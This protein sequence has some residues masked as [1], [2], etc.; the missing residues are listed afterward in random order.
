[1]SA[2]KPTAEQISMNPF[3]DHG[4]GCEFTDS[5]AF[6]V[7]DKTVKARMH[8]AKYGPPEETSKRTAQAWSA[9]FGF[10]IEPHQVLMALAVYHAIRYSRDP[11]DGKTL[12]DL[13]G[14]VRMAE[15]LRGPPGR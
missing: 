15:I 1:M 6:M 2:R 13:A 11:T 10:Q 12:H 3:T 7:A 5:V 9:I 8:D 14:Q 4:E